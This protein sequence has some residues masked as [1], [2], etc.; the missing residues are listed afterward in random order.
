MGRNRA[1]HGQGR[2]RELIRAKGTA[3]PSNPRPLVHVS[4]P[5]RAVL[6]RLARAVAARDDA[7]D[8]KRPLAEVEVGEGPHVWLA[9]FQAVHP[10]NTPLSQ[11]GSVRSVDIMNPVRSAVNAD[12]ANV[13]PH[14]HLRPTATPR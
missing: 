10:P 1:S 13:R 4:I 2:P 11:Q 12:P 8:E 5:L 9:P 6:V 3:E 14:P 7:T